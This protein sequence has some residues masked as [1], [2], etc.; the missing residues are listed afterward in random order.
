VILEDC[1]SMNGT[2]LENGERLRSGESRVL[3]SN[4]RFYLGSRNNM[5][6]VT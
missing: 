3:S 2:Y 1:G 5:F 6:Q 4:G